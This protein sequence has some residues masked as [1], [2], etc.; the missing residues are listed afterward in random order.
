MSNRFRQASQADPAASALEFALSAAQRVKTMGPETAEGHSVGSVAF[1]AGEHGHG[2]SL[3]CSTDDASAGQLADAYEATLA[4][5]PLV[6][7]RLGDQSPSG[8]RVV[9]IGGSTWLEALD[10]TGI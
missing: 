8:I 5:W 1:H 3:S 7:D 9:K 2:L 4:A 10:D 6:K